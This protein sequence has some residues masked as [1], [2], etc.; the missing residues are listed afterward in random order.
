MATGLG[1]GSYFVRRPGC[2][3]LVGEV[4]NSADLHEAS[5]MQGV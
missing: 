4:S 1:M 5:K 2:A 3:D